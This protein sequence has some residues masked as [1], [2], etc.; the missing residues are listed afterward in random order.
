[1][2]SLTSS[3]EEIS[4]VLALLENDLQQMLSHCQTYNWKFEIINTHNI[5]IFV[6]SD[7]LHILFYLGRNFFSQS[8]N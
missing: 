7:S 8:S 4:V 2:H 5:Q 1:M 6:P 3:T